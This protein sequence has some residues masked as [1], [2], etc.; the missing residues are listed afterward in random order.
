MI[1]ANVLQGLMV[2]F[3]YI[4]LNFSRVVTFKGI[5]SLLWKHLSL[6][7]YEFIGSCTHVGEV[8]DDG[9]ILQEAT[10]STDQTALHKKILNMGGY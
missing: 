1:H 5:R 7:Q 6:R 3:V 8:I 10:S 9:K 2:L 4:L